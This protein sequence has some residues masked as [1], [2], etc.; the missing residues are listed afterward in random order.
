MAEKRK[1]QWANAVSGYRPG[2]ASAR[3]ASDA[4]P[5]RPW[6]VDGDADAE[7]AERTPMMAWARTLPTDQI[8]PDSEQP[9]R[10]FDGAGLEELAASIRAQGILQPLVVRR[11]GDRPGFTVVAGE[12]RLRAARLA[13]L[14]EVPCMVLTGESLKDARLAQLAE[15][16]Q[17]EDLAP[18]EEALAVARL[19]E[20]DRL[21]QEELARTLGKSSTYISRLFSISRIPSSEYERFSTL[22][23][24][25]SVLYEYS[26]LPADDQIRDLASEA[27]A[28][29]ATVKDIEAIRIEYA[30][31]KNRRGRPRAEKR[32]RRGRRAKAPGHAE[33]LKRV[34]EALVATAGDDVH[35]LDVGAKRLVAR[36]AIR[37]VTWLGEVLGIDP[38]SEGGLSRL[39]AFAL[40]ETTPTCDAPL[41]S[42]SDTADPEDRKEPSAR[43][44]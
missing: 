24:P 10:T 4:R 14:D 34:V 44:R 23:I 16:L 22:K 26:Q 21:N 6:H 43:P 2:S 36:E 41:S 8:E 7:A 39:E 19:A 15:N 5:T 13:G 28:R 29:G 3:S 38:F 18:M 35:S 37:L 42:L 33:A 1:G 27:I 32:P 9:R 17:R 11:N 30:G 12:R 25:A 40:G 20:V 31:S